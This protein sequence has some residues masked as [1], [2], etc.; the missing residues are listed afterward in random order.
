MF[1]NTVK[2]NFI[3][4]NQYNYLNLPKK[5]TQNAQVT[6]Y[7]YRADGVK[8]KKFF[9]DLE[10]DYLD[11]FQYQF[12]QGSVAGSELKFVPTYGGYFNFENNRYIYNYTD[13]LGNVRV[14]YFHN[15][16][17]IEILE[18]N[19]YYPF[20]LKHLGYNV[21][22]GNPSYQYK[23]NG[24]ELQ[25]TGM[26]DYGWRQYMPDLGRWIQSDPLIKDLNLLLTQIILMMTMMTK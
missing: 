20:G 15:S 21:L 8:V 24:K 23:Y 26:Y 25:E 7:V 11:G 5:I 22:V 13:H 1:I 19:N 17:G 2:L 9:N 3:L 12:S 16:T 14:S 18:E 4:K 6:D 10:T